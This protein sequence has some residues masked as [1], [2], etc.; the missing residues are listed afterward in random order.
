[1]ADGVHFPHP[2][3]G[4]L[5]EKKNGM[6][7]A[8]LAYAVSHVIF[9]PVLDEG[10]VCAEYRKKGSLSIG[11]YVFHSHPMRET[12]KKETPNRRRQHNKLL[13]ERAQR[14]Q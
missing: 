3:Q 6:V 5:K 1:M 2:S 9:F 13:S 11:A 14:Q 12:G 10:M 7:V 4:R 8:A